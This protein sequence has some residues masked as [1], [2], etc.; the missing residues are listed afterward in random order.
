M[1]TFYEEPKFVAWNLTAAENV[2][3]DLDEGEDPDADLGG[4]NFNTGFSPNRPK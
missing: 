3:A 1:K 4:S 2:A